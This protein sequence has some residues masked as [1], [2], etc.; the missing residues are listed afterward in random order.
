PWA[1]ILKRPQTLK[2]LSKAYLG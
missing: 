1:G 2:P